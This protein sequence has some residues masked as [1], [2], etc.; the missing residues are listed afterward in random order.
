MIRS[1]MKLKENYPCGSGSGPLTMSADTEAATGQFPFHVAIFG[2]SRQ[3][4]ICS[5]SL[6]SSKA[7]LTAAHCIVNTNNELRD[8]SNYK[9]L[10]G[11]VDLKNLQGTE[12]IRDV[13]KMIK[14][15]DYE[16]RGVMLEDIAL[17][18]IKG[19]LQFTDKVSP[20]CLFQSHTPITNQVDQQF[21]VLG[22]GSNANSSDPSQYLKH[23]QMTII[24]RRQCT[25]S[26]L[27]FGLL[28]EQSA[29]CAKSYQNEV[30]CPGDSGGKIGSSI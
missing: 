14:H 1:K 12:A 5:G 10:F 6:I 9:L 13:K 23:G 27:K 18:I 24:T 16:S 26:Y 25:Q 11:A 30:A 4:Y 19:N 17:I 8:K 7:V 29:F 21:T 28:S 3:Y 22:F 2:R 20:I 15:P